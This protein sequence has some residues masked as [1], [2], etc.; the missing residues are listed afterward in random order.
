RPSTRST[1]SCGR[2]T[3]SWWRWLRGTWPRTSRGARIWPTSSTKPWRVCASW[4]SWPPP[5][6]RVHPDGYGRSSG[7]PS[8]LTR[9]A[10]RTTRPGGG[11]SRGRGSRRA[12]LSSPGSRSNPQPPVEPH[13]SHPVEGFAAVEAPAAVDTHCHLFL[14]DEDPADVLA[15]ARRH[16]VGSLICVGIDQESSRRS[17]ELAES[18]PGVFA[19]AGV[20]P[21]SAASFESRTGSSIGALLA[22]PA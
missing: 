9:R 3:G 4:P 11:S 5:R 1:S 14:L 10:F 17:L 21:P 13:T 16:G 6:C 12:S 18:F 2:P 20:H 15:A 22:D 19:T 8:R 7:S